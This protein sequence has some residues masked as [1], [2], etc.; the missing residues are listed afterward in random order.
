LRFTFQ[1][2]HKVLYLKVDEKSQKSKTQ[3]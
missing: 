1:G 2:L 3:G